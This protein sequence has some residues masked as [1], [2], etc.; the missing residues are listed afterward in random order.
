M[1]MAALEELTKEPRDLVIVAAQR[2]GAAEFPVWFDGLRK[3]VMAQGG[4]WIP[5]LVL[6]DV[7]FKVLTEILPAAVADNWYFDILVPAHIA[8]LP[9]RVANLLRIHDHLHELKRYSAAL[10]DITTKVT[11]LESQM[12]DLR[13]QERGDK[14]G[15]TKS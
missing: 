6:A 2:V 12:R 13:G 14:P 7:P 3:R 10:E 4:I 5:A 8:S 9:I 11:M 1:R 15:V